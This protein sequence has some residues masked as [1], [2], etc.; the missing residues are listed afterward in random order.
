M[1]ACACSLILYVE[2]NSKNTYESAKNL[3]SFCKKERGPFLLITGDYQ[4][5]RSYLAF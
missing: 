4:S 1:A 3:E 2:Q 5:L